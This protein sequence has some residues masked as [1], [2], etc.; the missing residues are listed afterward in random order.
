MQKGEK[1]K[2]YSRSPVGD[3][4]LVGETH[5]GLQGLRKPAE[6]LQTGK[7]WQTEKFF[8]FSSHSFLYACYRNL[9][10]SMQSVSGTDTCQ[11]YIKI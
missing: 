10:I 9:K 1:K 6:W 4:Q 8:F 3:E 5:S 2:S 11:S 7:N